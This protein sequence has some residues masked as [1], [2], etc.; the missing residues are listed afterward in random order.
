[1]E[2][3]KSPE[4]L[5]KLLSYSALYAQW[6]TWSSPI[7]MS[8][9]AQGETGWGCGRRKGSRADPA[10]NPH[11]LWRI[12]KV[13]IASLCFTFAADIQGMHPRGL[14]STLGPGLHLSL[15][16]VCPCP[17]VLPTPTPFPQTCCLPPGSL[18]VPLVRPTGFSHLMFFSHLDMFPF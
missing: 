14:K 3:Q 17:G 15:G 12:H 18:Y 5:S 16:A 1:M 9:R 11:C 8:R 2:G 10:T 6:L 4:R 7:E 13:L